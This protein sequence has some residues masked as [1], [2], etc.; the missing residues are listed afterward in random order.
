[1]SNNRAT[2]R[3]TN[4]PQRVPVSG[5]RDILTVY[6]K[7]SNKQYRFVK[8]NDEGGM[9]IQQYIRGG[10]NFTDPS[11][12]IIVGE[13]NVHK[14]KKGEGSIVR[15]PAG[16]GQWLYLM[17]IKKEWYDE[18]QAAKAEVVNQSESAITGTR[19][20]DSDDGQYGS[21]KIKSAQGKHY[22]GT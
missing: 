11:G 12:G 10:W 6:G 8:D 18:D 1:M 17:E 22:V 19:S 21:V 3:A 4:K 20:P 15:R 13:E 14:S 9:R 2:N 7:D 5:Q 16:E